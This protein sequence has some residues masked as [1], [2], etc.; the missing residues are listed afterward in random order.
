MA[1]AL[2]FAI[3]ALVQAGCWLPLIM[4]VLAAGDRG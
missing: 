2:A 1:I 4:R 3:V